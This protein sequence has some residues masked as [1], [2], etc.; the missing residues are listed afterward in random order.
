LKLSPTLFVISATM[1]AV[2]D[3]M[4]IPAAVGWFSP[5]YDAE[6]FLYSA[7]IILMPALIINL[8]SRRPDIAILPRHAFTV[9]TTVWVIAAVGGA[10]PIAMH[11]GI[12]F[13]D[14]FFESMSGITTTGSTV[15]VG[16]DRKSPAL[17]LWRSKL[18]WIGGLGFV[19]M[20]I[21]ILP[22]VVVGGMRLY[23]SETSDWSE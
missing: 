17:L 22:L 10:L 8:T 5:F 15:L 21:A 19:M 16:L 7:L 3:L 11:P 20:A 13:T 4:L 1:L 6:P 9:T 12:T 14:A 2:G 18:Q 23:R